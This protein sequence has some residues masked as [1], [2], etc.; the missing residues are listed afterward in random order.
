MRI[1]RAPRLCRDP[2]TIACSSG[3]IDTLRTRFRLTRNLRFGVQARRH[4]TPV[5]G[6]RNEILVASVAHHETR[7][8]RHVADS[9]PVRV[10]DRCCSVRRRR[11]V[12]R[13][14]VVMDDERLPE[15]GGNRDRA[16]GG[17]RCGSGKGGRG[18]K[19][20][21]VFEIERVQVLRS[22]AVTCAKR[23][24]GFADICPHSFEMLFALVRRMASGRD[25]CRS[26]VL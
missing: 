6:A 22:T 2:S 11:M 13:R 10:P 16:S 15:F 4:P 18:G 1:A 19:V 9:V 21:I 26:E 8:P 24:S 17:G 7:S 5:H 23:N 14:P 20:R 3:R 25:D 12:S